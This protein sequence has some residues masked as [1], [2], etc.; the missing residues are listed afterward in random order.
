MLNVTA[1]KPNSGI[2][3]T[4]LGHDIKLTH[5]PLHSLI[6]MPET[7]SYPEAFN[8]AVNCNLGE[9]FLSV[10]GSAIQW[11]DCKVDTGEFLNWI[12]EQFNSY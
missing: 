11:V 7:V 2:N 5:N 3:L 6:I 1:L 12:E 9:E 10:Y 8:Y 4:V